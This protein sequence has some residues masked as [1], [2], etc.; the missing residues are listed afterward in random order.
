M[1]ETPVRLNAGDAHAFL[2]RVMGP[3][4]PT[5]QTFRTWG[6]P[7]GP[8]RAG[9]DHAARLLAPVDRVKERGLMV[10]YWSPAQLLEFAVEWGGP[11]GRAASLDLDPAAVDAMARELQARA[12]SLDAVDGPAAA[13]VG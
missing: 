4:A 5:Y 2:K 8:G 6:R 11:H 13:A 3:A 7:S 1:N 10:Q 12:R 9:P